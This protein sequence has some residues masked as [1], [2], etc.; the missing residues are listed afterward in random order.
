MNMT[1]TDTP[2]YDADRFGASA[3]AAWPT[4]GR[5]LLGSRRALWEIPVR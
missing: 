2:A 4:A 1:I 5:R 3:S